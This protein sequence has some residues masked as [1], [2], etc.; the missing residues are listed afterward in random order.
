MLLSSCDLLYSNVWFFSFVGALTSS[1]INLNYPDFCRFFIAKNVQ[2][3]IE[4]DNIMVLIAYIRI[5][6]QR[7][8]SFVA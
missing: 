7:Q 8:L 6:C 2:N 4:D 5:D 3:Y 1:F